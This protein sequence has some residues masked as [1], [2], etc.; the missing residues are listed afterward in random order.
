MAAQ[1]V[2]QAL[3]IE[4]GLVDAEMVQ[5]AMVMCEALLVLDQKRKAYGRS[6]RRVG[7][8]G[9]VLKVSMKTER[10]MNLLWFNGDHVE[11]VLD[12]GRDTIL[13]T[14]IDL[15]NYAC[16]GV[17]QWRQGSKYGNRDR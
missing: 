8:M 2:L 9:T 3:D 15:L 1:K 4:H 13:D 12:N 11:R 14:W 6:W 5:H 17:Q 7:Y 16:F 10:L